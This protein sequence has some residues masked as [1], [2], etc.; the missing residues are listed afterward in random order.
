MLEI[1]RAVETGFWCTA[2][3]DRRAQRGAFLEIPSAR[4]KRYVSRMTVAA[5]VVDRVNELQS[6]NMN[7]V[8]SPGLSLKETAGL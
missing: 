4:G 6:N 7:N 3:Q 1:P 2:P 5:Q 8:Q